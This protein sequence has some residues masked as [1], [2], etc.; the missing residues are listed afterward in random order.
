METKP[1]CRRHGRENMIRQIMGKDIRENILSLRFVL[2]LLLITTLFAASGV[3]FAGRYAR[4]SEDYWKHRSD[5][6]SAL[7]AAAR[8]LYGLAFY[9][10]RVVRK[11]SPLM[12]CAE[13]FERS[14]PDS[15]RFNA[16]TSELPQIEAQNNFVL[17]HFSDVDWTFIISMVLSFV[18][19]VFTYDGICGEREQGTLRLMLAHAVS[20]HEVLLGKYGAALCTLGIPLGI[21]L[22]ISLVI[23][24]SSPHV[25]LTSGEW[26]KV[27]VIIFVSFL[28]LSI[29][30]LLGLLVSSRSVHAANGMVILLLAWVALGILVP[31]LGRIL[32]DLSVPGVTNRELQKELSEARSRVWD[33]SSQ[34]GPQAGNASQDPKDPQN[35][36]AARAQLNIALTNATNRVIEEH[37]NRMLAQVS[38]GW[39]LVCVRVSP[40]AVYQRACAAI[41]GTGIRHCADLRRQVQRYQRDLMQY[42][43]DEDSKDPS[44]LHLIFNERYC[45]R[46]WN[47]ISGRPADFDTLP[48]FQERS[49][50]LGMSVK[51]VIWDM[52]LLVAFNGFSF[53]AA[54]VSFLRYDVR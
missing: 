20:R 30:I 18:A 26:W 37:H 12:F 39:N 45:A 28:Y 13:G 22:L 38:S 15:L 1:D 51:S 24:V 8:Q 23:V 25:A 27:L 36:P 21:G 35:N 7:R 10:Q 50:P 47:T 29:F 11:P 43:R 3:V 31:S 41:A 44:S 53:A 4:Q 33:K 2:S 49:V 5:N 6:S 54:F 19:L 46:Y 9:Q 40:V 48:E 16:F 32:S 42:I 17:P 34:F 52:G 14:L